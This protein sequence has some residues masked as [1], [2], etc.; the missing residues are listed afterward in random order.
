MPMTFIQSASTTA[1]SLALA[2]TAGAAITWSSSA[3]LSSRAAT[4]AGALEHNGSVLRVPH[5]Q[6]VESSSYAEIDGASWCSAWSEGASNVSGVPEG[7]LAT[8]R[9]NAVAGGAG[10]LMTSASAY[11]TATT[12]LSM[13]T[14]SDITLGVNISRISGE[15]GTGVVTLDDGLS[16]S[17]G[18][19]VFNLSAG[20]H[21]FMIRTTVAAQSAGAAVQMTEQIDT[22]FTVIPAPAGGV[23]LVMAA[24]TSK[25]RRR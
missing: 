9:A 14:D 17:S 11:A 7:M 8:T 15:V 23:L 12:Y 1:C 10:L 20:T 19:H 22:S 6:A 5:S 3:I 18:W 21:T 24:C 25:R 16:L 4:P 13:T 2:S